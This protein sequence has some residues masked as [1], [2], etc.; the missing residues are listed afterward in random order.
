M[1]D[2]SIIVHDNLTVVGG[3][4]GARRFSFAVGAWD[5]MED[6]RN[7]HRRRS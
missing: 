3:L 6:G 2:S 5:D 7:S 4:G 1:N